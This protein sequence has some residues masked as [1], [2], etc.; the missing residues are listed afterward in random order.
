MSQAIKR[1]FDLRHD[2][3]ENS[4]IDRSIRAGERIGGTNM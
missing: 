2:Q 4:E 3:D 1:L